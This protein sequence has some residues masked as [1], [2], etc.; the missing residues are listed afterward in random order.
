M[1][2]ATA[3]VCLITLLA[4]CAKV[5]VSDPTPDAATAAICTSVM[6][7][8]PQRVLD[9]GLR[10]VEQQVQHQGEEI[11]AVSQREDAERSR[12]ATRV[13]AIEAEQCR[14]LTRVGAIEQD[15]AAMRATA[16]WFRGFFD[17]TYL[18]ILKAQGGM[19]LTR[20]EVDFLTKV[21]D[22]RHGPD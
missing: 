22:T 18:E 21:L 16:E 11:T 12:L 19:K 10:K 15:L 20:P 14:L 2:R 4:G 5:A 8:L 1:K 7:D 6:A 3:A 17:D 13:G 9:Q